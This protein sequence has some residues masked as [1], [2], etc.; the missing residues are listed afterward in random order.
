MTVAKSLKNRIGLITCHR[1]PNHG[2][3][4]QAWSLCEYLSELGYD[5]EIIDY[6]YPNLYHLNDVHHNEIRRNTDTSNILKR[7]KRYIIDRWFAC[8]R[9]RGWELAIYKSLNLLFRNPNKLYFR[10]LKL[11]A[12]SYISSSELVASK[13]DYDILMSGSDQIWNPR[14]S[15]NDGI[16]F[17]QFGNKD[18]K[19]I[20]YSSSFGVSE[21]GTAYRDQYAKWLASFSHIATREQSG[22]EIVKRIAGKDAVHVLDPVML[23]SRSQWAEFL[24]ISKYVENKT[25]D[26]IVT[27]CLDYVYKG[28]I[29]Y[30]DTIMQQIAKNKGLKCATLYKSNLN[31]D[32]VKTFSEKIHP[33]EFVNT[34]MHADFALVSSFHGLAFCI[35]F[36]TPFLVVMDSRETSDARL[37]DMLNTFCLNDRVLITGEEFDVSALKEIDWRNIDMI[38]NRM[39][40]ISKQYLK[41]ALNE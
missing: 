28:I 35:L 34:I 40:D 29:D 1:I 19:R 36:H 11:S 20:A 38:Y 3:F 14:F 23:F 12:K 4:L 9:K 33:F 18:T 22:T 24:D 13:L 2:S 41:K 5:V 26:Y 39:S 32:K 15:G 17:L 25:E 31:A 7:L 21:I 16:F 27:Y 8:N 10:Q 37:S 30:A 6:V